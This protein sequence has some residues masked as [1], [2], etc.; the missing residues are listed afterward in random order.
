M[1]VGSVGGY[2]TSVDSSSIVTVRILNMYSNGCGCGASCCDCCRKPV[3]YLSGAGGIFQFGTT[4]ANIGSFIISTQDWT[5][6]GSSVHII[7]VG[8]GWTFHIPSD[9]QISMAT[10]PYASTLLTSSLS[11]MG[12]VLSSILT[13]SSD[14][15]QRVEFQGNGLISNDGSLILNSQRGCS[16]N[17]VQ[18][19]SS[20]S[21]I[22]RQL[23]TTFTTRWALWAAHYF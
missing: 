4:N 12:L 23:A 6:Y 20:G 1:Y 18:F 16:F 5:D 7:N 2:I 3:F 13:L 19:N 8:T 14:S 10:E 22:L 15:N 17:N 11:L 21:F 9:M